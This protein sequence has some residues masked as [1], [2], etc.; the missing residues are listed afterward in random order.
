MHSREKRKPLG[1]FS[2]VFCELAQGAPRRPAGAAGRLFLR[3][4]ASENRKIFEK[5]SSG[6]D[7]GKFRGSG[8]LGV[9][10]GSRI[11]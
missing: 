3:Y 5:I 11:G 2:L 9:G 4:S 10:L 7:R 1:I 6:P 8:F